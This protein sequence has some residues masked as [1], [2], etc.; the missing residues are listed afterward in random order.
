M[1]SPSILVSLPNPVNEVISAF[2]STTKFTLVVVSRQ[3]GGNLSKPDAEIS[4]SVK[5]THCDA[6]ESTE[7]S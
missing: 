4:P 2:D 5:L 1:T 3:Y 6:L 7:R